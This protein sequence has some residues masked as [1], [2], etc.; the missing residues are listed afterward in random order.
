MQPEN[1]DVTNR[2]FSS[3]GEAFLHMAAMLERSGSVLNSDAFLEALYHRE[4]LGS[5]YMGECLA[6]PHGKSE[7]V[8]RVSAALCRC[9]PFGYESCGETGKVSMIIMLAIPLTTER[10]EYLRTLSNLSRILMRQDFRNVIQNSADPV[11][12]IAA[13]NSAIDSLNA[14]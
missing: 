6:V 5:T 2:A 11:E 10:T 13:G 8:E 9:E 4:T 14:Q 12:I 7:V 3:K 1:I